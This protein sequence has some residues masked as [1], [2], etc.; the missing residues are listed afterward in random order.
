MN[1]YTQR[2]EKYWDVRQKE[3]KAECK[4]TICLE[5]YGGGDNKKECEKI[6]HHVYCFCKRCI[7]HPTCLRC[8]LYIETGAYL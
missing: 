4:L 5:K 2:A 6:G 1:K 3:L 8:R 7:R